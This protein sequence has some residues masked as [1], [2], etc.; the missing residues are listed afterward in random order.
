[1]PRARDATP[2][3]HRTRVAPQPRGL[4]RPGRR[5]GAW[6]SASS[7]RLPLLLLATAGLAAAALWLIRDGADDLA[8]EHR[9][10]IGEDAAAVVQAGGAWRPV[11]DGP[12][13]SRAGAAAV[14]TGSELVV[15]GGLEPVGPDMLEERADG[16][17]YD[18]RRQRWQALP[19]APLTA[20]RG[21]AVAWT[22]EAFLVWGGEA[23]GGH[24]ALAD[25]AALVGA[26]WQD[27][28]PSPL[29]PRAGAASAWSGSEWLLWG[30]R[31]PDGDDGGWLGDG[32]AY[33]PYN[34]RWR[35]LPPAPVGA[36]AHPHGVWTATE[37]VVWGG[38]PGN[39][40]IGEGAAYDLATA[41]W[42]RLPPVPFA[43]A[44]PAAAVW[45]GSRL[46][47]WAPTEDG[48][49]SGGAVYD[50]NA[51]RWGLLWPPLG[52]DGGQPPG[53]SEAVWTGESVIF[54]GGSDASTFGVAYDPLRQRW[55]ALPPQTPRSG[56]VAAWAGD[57]LLVWGGVDEA[58]RPVPAAA[59]RTD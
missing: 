54:V 28:S 8:V 14:W 50:P 49:S 31:R 36:L 38:A 11:P 46:V 53:W 43:P 6:E 23:G 5:G 15:W 56:F 37:F 33:D 26:T 16:A 1:M 10:V 32:A 41:R 12:L 22:G 39:P 2:V 48:E 59:W 21:A 13:G 4:P 27:L 45:T 42:R 30:G 40:S 34:D 35:L 17:A 29:A 57:E 3:R 25:G 19:D 51:G 7:R 18:P 58:S 55:A 47:M 44:G 9:P 20:R 24:G 52:R